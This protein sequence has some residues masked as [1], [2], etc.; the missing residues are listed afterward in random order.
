[1]RSREGAPPTRWRTLAIC[2][3]ILLAGPIV[4]LSISL[5][6][7]EFR[8]ALSERAGQVAVRARLL[9]KSNATARN[10]YFLKGADGLAEAL[11]ATSGPVFSKTNPP[12]FFP[13]VM[14][15]GWRVH[16]ISKTLDALTANPGLKRHVVIASIDAIRED[17]MQMLQLHDRSL[18]VIRLYHPPPLL[19]LVEALRMALGRGELA[20]QMIGSL[21]TGANA[22]FALRFAFDSLH[23]R[24]ALYLED[25]ILP[26]HYFLPSM[27]GSIDAVTRRPEVEARVMGILA[28]VGHQ[29]CHAHELCPTEFSPHGYVYLAK[30]WPAIRDQW[31]NWQNWDYCVHRTQ[32][33]RGLTSVSRHKVH[34]VHV[35]ECGINYGASSKCDESMRWQGSKARSNRSRSAD[36][37]ASGRRLHEHEVSIV[38]LD[39]KPRAPSTAA[40]RPICR[41]P[42]SVS[43]FPCAERQNLKIPWVLRQLILD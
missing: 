18:P 8:C 12:A 28:S 6:V 24:A 5:L 4:F 9:T 20:R 29:R 13:V 26:G 36:A 23:A 40:K 38:R 10:Q 3:M 35:G 37:A 33:R 21:P 1:M 19:G 2:C 43:C 34:A 41:T 22:L 7:Y 16:Y 39:A 42:W 25:D 31:T 30:H 32:Q 15:L 14:P 11:I 17:L 27:A